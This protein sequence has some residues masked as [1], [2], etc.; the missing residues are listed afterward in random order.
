MQGYKRKIVYVGVF[1]TIAI[2]ICSLSLSTL[3][4]SSLA[5]ATILSMITSTIAVTWN[6][7][8]TSVFEAWESRQARHGRSITRR[9]GHAVGFESGL[10]IILVPTITWWLNVSLGQAFA[11][12]LGLA[13]FFLCYTFIFN[14]AFD[15]VFGLTVSARADPTRP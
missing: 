1:E 10:L 2:A 5:S 13:A 9:I 3:S 4:N 12:N 15:R 7:F 8:F 6:Y 11:M 14:W